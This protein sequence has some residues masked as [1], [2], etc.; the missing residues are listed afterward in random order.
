MLI[1]VD[2][3]PLR[4][5]CGSQL[6]TQNFFSKSENIGNLL[7]IPRM[8][9]IFLKSEK[10]FYK[11]AGEPAHAV[12]PEMLHINEHMYYTQL[13]TCL[14]HTAYIYEDVHTHCE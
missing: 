11:D 1:S 7:G 8:L 12:V 10:K 3:H 6:L 13:P 9:P 5:C 14:N 2:V 4:R